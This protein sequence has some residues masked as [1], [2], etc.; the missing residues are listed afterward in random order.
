MMGRIS[1]AIIVCA[2]FSFLFYTSFIPSPL[3]IF[4]Q[5]P[6]VC[7]HTLHRWR[8]ANELIKPKSGLPVTV[9]HI[10]YT[11]G[12]LRQAV[13]VMIVKS[14]TGEFSVETDIRTSHELPKD[15]FAIT[16]IDNELVINTVVAQNNKLLTDPAT[17]GSN[18][19]ATIKVLIT[20]PV[21]MP[22][23]SLAFDLP[24]ANLFVHESTHGSLPSLDVKIGR[25]NVV[26]SN[27]QRLHI[28]TTKIEIDDGRLY[29]NL[30][31][32]KVL[33]TVMGKGEIDLNI[34]YSPDLLGANIDIKQQSGS[35]KITIEDKFYR[36]TT[37][38]YSLDDGLLQLDYP[39]SY[40]GT[41][42]L[43]SISGKVKL[44]GKS[45]DFMETSKAGELPAWA[46]AQHGHS[47]EPTETIVKNG[48]GGIK[49][50]V[51][52]AGRHSSK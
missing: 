20:V 47:I 51:G 15:S 26:F 11:N 4:S 24:E 30:L 31:I 44:S 38:T 28:G 41:L 12:A 19:C 8:G 23:T 10:D 34:A 27:E 42:F 32:T 45:L 1:T 14:L 6:N 17:S 40:E 46:T 21:S 13:S 3:S 43:Q 36:P 9:K 37:G 39:K 7:D 33:K 16:Y 18:H 22:L 25:G 2:L 29:G 48:V 5:A 50:V 52:N 49:M 35:Q